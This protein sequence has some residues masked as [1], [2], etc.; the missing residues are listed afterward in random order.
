[1]P[2]RFEQNANR[3]FIEIG[4]RHVASGEVGNLSPSNTTGVASSKSR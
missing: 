4:L 3:I 2:Q 1:M